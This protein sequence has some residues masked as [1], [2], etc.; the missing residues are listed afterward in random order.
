MSGPAGRRPPATRRGRSSPATRVL[1][2]A[3]AVLAV[4]AG[5]LLACRTGDEPA[6]PAGAALL[7]AGGDARWSDLA[8]GGADLGD[9]ALDRATQVAAGVGGRSL[10][11]F[12]EGGAVDHLVEAGLDGDVAGSSIAVPASLPQLTALDV[13]P[14]GTV[15]V[16]G[17]PPGDAIVRVRGAGWTDVADLPAPFAVASLEITPGGPV[18]A[19]G[20]EGARIA[21]IRPDGTARHLLGPP[22]SGAAV[23]SGE[24]LGPVGAVADL[25]DGQVAFV[26]GPAGGE[27][28]HLLDDR[29]VRRVETRDHGAL[30]DPV[31]GT[32]ERPDAS[33]RPDRRAMTPLATAPRGRVLTTGLGPGGHPRIALV[34]ID[35]GAI[36][37]VADLEDV[38]P[39]ID[40]P[41]SA[42]VV[43]DDLVF[44][45]LGRLWM[46]P[47]VIE[48]DARDPG[49]PGSGHRSQTGPASSAISAHRAS[50]WRCSVV[51][52][53]MLARITYR[54][55]RRVW[56]R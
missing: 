51:Q 10:V 16:A 6:A 4:A 36:D 46:V 48:A 14:D 33:Q 9:V 34:D 40:Q 24:V 15:A 3:P 12:V 37:V 21:S 20:V 52:A 30:V 22:G 17:G 19:G 56:V 39:T 2:A 29:A 26:A 53:P 32:A 54:P 13:G 44:L 5:P 55:P 1:L 11:V 7:A 50:A 35:S 41:V 43:G 25:G 49:P 45:A 47:D 42:A 8:G 31:T 28:L 18:L 27:A 23:E 38:E